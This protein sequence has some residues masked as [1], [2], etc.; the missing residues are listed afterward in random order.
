M[1]YH[2]CERGYVRCTVTPKIWTSDYMVIDEVEKPGGKT[3]RRA[4][5][6]IEAGSPIVR[7]A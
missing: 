3:I 2:D 6:V 1:H 5:F 7:N 4:S